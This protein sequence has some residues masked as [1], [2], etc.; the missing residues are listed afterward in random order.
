MILLFSLII[1]V[2]TWATSRDCEHSDGYIRNRL[3]NMTDKCDRECGWRQCGDVCVNLVGGKWCY[4]GEKKLYLDWTSP[5][6]CCVDHTPNLKTDVS[7]LQDLSLFNLLNLL[8]DNR[9]HCN[10]KS[11]GDAYCPLGRVVHKHD[12]CN[13]H[14]NNDYKTSA[15]V[16]PESYYHCGDQTCDQARDMCRGYPL[17]PVS[18]DVSECDEDLKCSRF[19]LA[20]GSTSNKRVLVSDLSASHHYCDYDHYHNDG[21]YDTITRVDETDLNILSRRVHINYTSI[22][23]CNTAG[24]VNLPGLMCGEDCV[25]HR[26][27]CRE[28]GSVSCGNFSNDNNQL[29]AN[30]TFWKGK[31]CDLFLVNGVKAAVG[32]RCTG[33]TQHCSYSWYT[34]NIYT[35]KVREDLRGIKYSKLL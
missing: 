19:N 34:S 6:Y 20:L 29:C 3:D 2:P 25:E 13:N 27:W 10:F 33:A 1:Y 9:T 28:D 7:F 12:T 23:D 8:N 35:Y 18:R 16:G 14:C 17:C 21:R 30:T 4:C 15:V 11:N 31:S 5:Y 26:Y 32:R 24:E 22:R